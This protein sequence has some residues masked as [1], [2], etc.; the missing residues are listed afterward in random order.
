M[1]SYNL[2]VLKSESLNRPPHDP[3]QLSIA[4]QFN[5]KGKLLTTKILLRVLTLSIF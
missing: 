2:I 1:E 5:K 3:F 4:F